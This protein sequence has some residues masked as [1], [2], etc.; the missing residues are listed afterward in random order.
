MKFWRT[1]L[2][3]D[4]I[5]IPHGQITII[6]AR[7]KGCELCQ[8]YCPRHVL[9]MS[10]TFNAKGY[11]IPEVVDAPACVACGLCQI[12]C[13]EFAIYVTESEVGNRMSKVGV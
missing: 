4:Q 9:K 8:T 13:P 2:D 6:S 10:T 1:P 11:Y 3:S 5:V 12:L 7:C